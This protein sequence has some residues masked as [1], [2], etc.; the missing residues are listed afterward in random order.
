MFVYVDDVEAHCERA[1]AA[2]AEI[3]SEPGTHGDNKIYVASDCGGHQW[4][5][6]EPV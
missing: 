1:R 6:A 4:I 2:G 5:F 3:R